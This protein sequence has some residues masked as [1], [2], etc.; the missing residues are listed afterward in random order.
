MMPGPRI[1]MNKH[2]CMILTSR[3]K[4]V[5]LRPSGLAESPLLRIGL[6]L[7]LVAKELLDDLRR[8]GIMRTMAAGRGT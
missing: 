7:L 3:T 2:T 1:D 8:F 5:S 6:V 4:P